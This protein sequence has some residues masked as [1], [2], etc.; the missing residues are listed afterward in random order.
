MLIKKIL[1]LVFLGGFLLGCQQS[2]PRKEIDVPIDPHASEEDFIQLA[3]FYKPPEDGTSLSVLAQNFDTFIFTHYDEG[4]RDE[5]YQLDVDDPILE[6]LLF[7]QIQ[8]PGSCDARPYGNQ[9]AYK[10]G[11]FCSL[12]TEH[13]DW[14][15]RDGQGELIRRGKNIYMDPGNSA[16]REFWLER[17]NELQDLY[18]WEGIFID[19]VEASLNK[20]KRIG[21]L[22]AKYPDDESYQIAVEGFL[23]YLD[24]NIQDR[25]VYAN[26]IEYEDDSVWLRYL[27][28]LDGVMIEDFSVDY[29]E[30]YYFPA[31]WEEQLEMIVEAQEMGKSLILVSQGEMSDLERAKFSFASYLLISGGNVSFRYADSDSYEEVWLYESYF[32]PL[33]VPT[34]GYYEFES[35]WRRDFSK[36]YVYVNPFLHESKIEVWQ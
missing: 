36:G 1:L 27:K 7:V 33:G 34:S 5:L 29:N 24:E 26:I 28:F 16:Y 15:L 4:E 11:D 32:L 20:F 12:S 6:Y 10:I 22:P 9:V 2:I 14:F 25:P 35:G 31:D 21:Q 3:W 8:D 18:G 13:P 19:N 17:A 30:R 23:V